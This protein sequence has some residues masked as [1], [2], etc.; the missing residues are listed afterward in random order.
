MVD[1]HTYVH[2]QGLDNGHD[3]LII[4]KIQIEPVHRH[5]RWVYKVLLIKA[6]IKHL[7]YIHTAQSPT[8]FTKFRFNNNKDDHH[9]SVTYSLDS[10]TI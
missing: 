8:L 4:I 3:Q 5:V 7:Y 6:Q 9:S 1:L 2:N 10:V